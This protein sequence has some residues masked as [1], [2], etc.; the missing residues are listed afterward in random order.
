MSAGRSQPLHNKYPF[1]VWGPYFGDYVSMERF[2]WIRRP[3]QSREGRGAADSF[4]QAFGLN[5]C[6]L[7]ADDKFF[8]AFSPTTF[9]SSSF[10]VDGRKDYAWRV[11]SAESRTIN[12]FLSYRRFSFHVDTLMWRKFVLTG[13]RIWIVGH[14]KLDAEIL[15]KLECDVGGLS[16]GKAEI[17]QPY[18]SRLERIMSLLRSS[19]VSA[20]FLFNN[21]FE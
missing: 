17:N 10:V 2:S 18:V 16:L 19:F 3:K 20:Y 7:E 4:N 1:L 5:C 6:L 12:P 13:F 9:A 14:Y 8:A 15:S 11:E 21:N